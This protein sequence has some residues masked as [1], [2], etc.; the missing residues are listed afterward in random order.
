MSPR[1]SECRRPNVGQRSLRARNSTGVARPTT[2]SLPVPWLL[3]PVSMFQSPRMVCCTFAPALTPR[4]TSSCD[5][6]GDGA[7]CALV[8]G[9]LPTLGEQ[10]VLTG[11]V[12]VYPRHL[13]GPL[14]VLYFP[15]PRPVDSTTG[16]IVEPL[17]LR[18]LSPARLCLAVIGPPFDTL[19]WRAVEW[20]VRK[21][22]I[23]ERITLIRS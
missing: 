5:R 20:G 14:P 18:S 22:L 15:C 6:C 19:L 13:S 8:V 3:L 9:P 17:P 7:P 10:L 21:S 4:R 12:A 11:P 1:K 16:S 2:T 23:S